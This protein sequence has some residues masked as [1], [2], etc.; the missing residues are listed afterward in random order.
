M[1]CDF[2]GRFFLNC[3]V[4]LADDN[5]KKISLRG[6]LFE[7]SPVLVI[8]VNLCICVYVHMCMFIRKAFKFGKYFLKTFESLKCKS[9]H[10]EQHCRA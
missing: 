1:F 9:R 5:D 3:L 4:T 6:F 8:P 7:T 10:I 2:F